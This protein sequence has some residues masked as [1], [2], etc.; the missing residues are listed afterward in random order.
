MFEGLFRGDDLEYATGMRTQQDEYEFDLAIVGAGAAGQFAA[1][2]AAENG[3]RVVLLEQ[4]P[5]PGMKLLASGGGRANLT[6]MQGHDEI[7]NAFGRQG[8]FMGAALAEMGPADVR[9]FLARLGV[10]TVVDD[11]QR[12]HPASQRAS[13]VQAALHRRMAQLNVATRV[14]CRVS[15][16]WVEDGRL[17]GVETSEGRIVARDVLLACGGRSWSKLGGTGGGYPLARQAGHSLVPL[18]PALVPLVTMEQWGRELA[19][20][21]LAEARVSIPLPKQSKAGITGDVLFT[22]RGLSGPAVIDLSGTVAELLGQAESVPIHIELLAGVNESQWSRK[23][24][25]W[26]ANHGRR[27][28]ATL[29]R[30]ELPASLARLLCRQAGLAEDATI[31]QLSAA[32]RQTLSKLLARLPLTVTDTE[33][34]ETAFV[35][36]GGVKLKEVN[37]QTL[38]SRLLPGLYLAGEILD[39]DGPTGGYN[40]QWA[41]ASGWLA[42]HC[43]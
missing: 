31:S 14:N 32:G 3:K 20:V 15:R 42:G 26:R 12:V 5:Q 19:G 22:H 21:S 9:E 4:M 35:T 17:V 11:K 28:V 23:L 16:L 2:A 36:R 37:P 43:R 18:T 33:G 39:L 7:V 34:F 38:E 8:R 13:D 41:F 25:T 27:E 6:T 29:L 40:L 10:K 1:I 24:E 30:D